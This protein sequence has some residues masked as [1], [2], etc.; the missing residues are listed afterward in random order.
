LSA[1]T[2][3]RLAD[4]DGARSPF[5]S[6]DN[7]CIGFF[8]GGKLKT[9]DIAGGAVR[10]LC[11]ARVGV[12]GAWNSDDVILFAPQV[13][14]PLYH[15]A[16]CGGA[17]APATPVPNEQSSQLHCWPVFLPRSD[18]FLFFVNRTG[19]GDLLRNGIHAGSLSSTDTHLVS[20]EIDGN[21]G[22]AGD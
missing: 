12:G 21:V 20:S 17:P 22:L 2:A 16:A 13:A 14:G 10:I 8:A 15:V 1:A 9:V 4:T 7:R 19:P 5:W 18:R 3:Q 11:E 6:P